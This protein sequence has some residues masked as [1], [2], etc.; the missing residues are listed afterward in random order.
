MYN[1]KS[2]ESFSNLIFQL[3]DNFS[4]PGFKHFLVVLSAILLG[5]PKK[6]WMPE[7]FWKKIS[8]IIIIGI[9]Q[10]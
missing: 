9:E 4:K 5:Q 3:K 2:L 10:K 8:T 6:T 1:K 7:N